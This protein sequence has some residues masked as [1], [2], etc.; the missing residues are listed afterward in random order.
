PGRLAD[1]QANF[2]ETRRFCDP[3]S[4]FLYTIF[5]IHGQTLSITWSRGPSV[6]MT[7]VIWHRSENIA[8]DPVSCATVPVSSEGG[9]A[10]WLKN[11]NL[12]NHLCDCE[13]GVCCAGTGVKRRSGGKKKAASFGS[14]PSGGPG[15]PT[16]FRLSA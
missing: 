6:S 14:P 10:K 7:G 16:R 1:H 3:S 13:P 8:F 11:K 2:P 5:C 12:Q 15:R 9:P 4:S